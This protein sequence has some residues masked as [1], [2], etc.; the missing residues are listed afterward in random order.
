VHSF[1]SGEEE[2]DGVL[3]EEQ[4]SLIVDEILKADDDEFMLEDN[5]P[6]PHKQSQENGDF[7]SSAKDKIKRIVIKNTTNK[8]GSKEKDLKL[9]NLENG[10]K[11][12]S[13]NLHMQ[14]ESQKAAIAAKEGLN[15]VFLSAH[16]MQIT[17]HSMK[18]KQGQKYFL[19]K[20]LMREKVAIQREK[21]GFRIIIP[22]SYKY[23]KADLSKIDMD[24]F[25][26]HYNSY[27]ITIKDIIKL[28]KE[29]EGLA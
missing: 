22:K 6:S 4:R 10:Y 18:E 19:N 21:G 7:E 12:R 28:I 23:G 9:K 29:Q 1:D 24:E 3:N 15:D 27:R 11:L 13:Y 16:K 5:S 8:E 25:A 2:A 20:E 17:K 14:N 26:N